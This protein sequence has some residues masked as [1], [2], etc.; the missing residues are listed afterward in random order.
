MKFTSKLTL[1]IGVICSVGCGQ[2]LTS[3]NLV[4]TWQIDLD[5]EECCT[6]TEPLSSKFLFLDTDGVCKLPVKRYGANSRRIIGHWE[7]IEQKGEC[8]IKVVDPEE[9]FSGFYTIEIIQVVGS[10]AQDKWITRI[11]MESGQMCFELFR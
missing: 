10:L 7:L 9:V 6:L 11:K 5:S 8:L 4:G 3:E 1:L 2:R